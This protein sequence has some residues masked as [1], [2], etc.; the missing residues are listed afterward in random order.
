MKYLDFMPSRYELYLNN[1]SRLNTNLGGFFTILVTLATTLA[2]IFFGIDLIYKE[3]PTSLTTE[4]YIQYP[5]IENKEMFFMLAP[6]YTN[7]TA[8]PNVDKKISLT[9]RYAYY[10]NSNLTNPS[11]YKDY[12]LVTC[13]RH[14]LIQDD[15]H[16]LLDYNNTSIEN[17]YCLPESFTRN[18]EGKDTKKQSYFQFLLK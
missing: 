17:Y 9:L 13:G 8:I 4:D 14:R 16:N 7:S 10:D 1:S 18:L 12:D 3:K 11:G 6:L 15:I 5:V 2:V